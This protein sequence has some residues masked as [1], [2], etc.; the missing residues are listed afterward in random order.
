VV[1]VV[2]AITKWTGTKT[3]VEEFLRRTE[4]TTGA[5]PTCKIANSAHD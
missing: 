2:T 4:S 3:V 5:A 1:P